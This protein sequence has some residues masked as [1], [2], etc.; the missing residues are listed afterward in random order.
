MHCESGVK[1]A[2]RSLDVAVGQHRTDELL[3]LDDLM[4]AEAFERLGAFSGTWESDRMAESGVETKD[5]FNLPTVVFNEKP[6]KCRKV[7]LDWE[8]QWRFLLFGHYAMIRL[9]P[10]DISMDQVPLS[11]LEWLACL[12]SVCLDCVHRS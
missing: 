2:D 9:K 3:E 12:K 11:H 6:A 4:A 10:K 5:A 7:V 1:P 8:T